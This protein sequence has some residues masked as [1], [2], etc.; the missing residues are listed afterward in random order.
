MLIRQLR[1]KINFIKL[2]L[3]ILKCITKFNYVKMYYIAFS[4]KKRKEKI[5]NKY[6]FYH[7]R[8]G[9]DTCNFL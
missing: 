4:K 1:S 5:L 7:Q 2:M 9:E 3:V 6:I 8:G